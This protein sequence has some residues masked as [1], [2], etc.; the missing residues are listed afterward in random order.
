MRRI[1][2]LAAIVV[3]PTLLLAAGASGAIHENVAKFCS[4]GNGNLDP[5]G[6]LNTQGNSFLRALQVTGIYTLE[7]GI[8]QA[9]EFGIDFSGAAPVFGPLPAPPA[10]TTA[11]SVFV[12]PTRPNAKL[13]DDFIW[14]FFVDPE[15]LGTPVAVYLQGYEL[16]HPAFG[17]CV[18]FA[19][20]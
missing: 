10:G 15:S 12:D 1:L 8:D 19:G 4:G 2:A 9:G 5:A 3:V 13:G 14:I 16:D 18:K 20:F 7:F 11:L 17:K 6:Q